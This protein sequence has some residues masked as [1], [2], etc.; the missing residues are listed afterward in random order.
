MLAQLLP[1]LNDFEHI[2]CSLSDGGV[3]E[4]TIA[5]NG[6]KTYHLPGGKKFALSAILK[7]REIIK[8]EKPDIISTR[9]IHADIF[10]RI[11]G[12]AFGVKKIICVTESILEQKKYDK[13][14]LIER[15][16]SFLVNR[17]V[18]VSQSVKNKYVRQAKINPNKIEVIYNGIDLEKFT[19]LPDKQTARQR[20]GFA[21]DE[22][23]IGYAAKMRR[24]RNHAVLLRAFSALARDLPK[25]K[26]ILAGDGPEKEKLINLARELKIEKQTIFLGNRDDVPLILRAL[27][28]FISLSTYEGMSVAILEAMAAGLPIVASDIAPNR[29]LIENE[30]NGL[31][32]PP[33]EPA[34]IA[35]KIITLLKNPDKK[36][37]LG[38]MAHEKSK[39]FTLDKTA[40]SFTKFYQTLVN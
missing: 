31:L 21:P 7:F 29:E 11:F 23:L 5:A 1:R 13:F 36:N 8:K 4:K 24:E 18:A 37:S 27:D 16:T 15:L 35:K 32:A 33:F 26:L 25:A 39:L 2:V 19:T 12:R 17:Y 38:I 10:G 34:I 28:V 9:L 20:L 40:V 14:F 6:V 22:I 3:L 30:K